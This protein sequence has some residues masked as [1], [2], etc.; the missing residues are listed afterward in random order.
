MGSATQV[1]SSDLAW[2]GSP[3]LNSFGPNMLLAKELIEAGY[4][5]PVRQFFDECSLFWRL[6]RGRLKS[7]AAVMDSNQMPNF[8]AN[9]IY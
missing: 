2:S 9:L 4:K 6:D 3:Q 5:E 7:W 1:K 8:G